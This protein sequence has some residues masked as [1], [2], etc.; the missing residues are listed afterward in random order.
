MLRVEVGVG[1]TGGGGEAFD[2]KNDLK[3]R[4]FIKIGCALT[5]TFILVF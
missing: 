4:I 3:W 2:E 5:C 1:G